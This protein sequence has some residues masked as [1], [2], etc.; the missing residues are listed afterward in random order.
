METGHNIQTTQ[1]QKPLSDKNKIFAA[2]LSVKAP[3]HL[4]FLKV[5][6]LNIPRH[7]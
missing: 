3:L 5:H 1:C 6:W 2:V 7:L 4:V